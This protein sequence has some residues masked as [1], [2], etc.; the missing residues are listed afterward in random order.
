MSYPRI[1]PTDRAAPVITGFRDSNTLL[2]SLLTGLA[3]EG[4]IVDQSVGDVRTGTVYWLGDFDTGDW[5][6]WSYLQGGQHISPVGAAGQ[7]NTNTGGL[8]NT[9]LDL[10]TSPT[11]HGTGWAAKL[12]S[13]NQA[14]VQSLS[15][16][17]ATSGNFTLSWN[18]STSATIAW[19]ETTANIGTK[20]NAMASVITDGGVYVNDSTSNLGSGGSLPGKTIYI[21]FKTPG[22]HSAFTVGNNTVAGGTP[23]ITTGTTLGVPDQTFITSTTT[24]STTHTAI[25]DDTYYGFSIYV[26]SSTQGQ[27]VPEADTSNGYF[28]TINPIGEQLGGAIDTAGSDGASVTNP[29]LSVTLNVDANGNFVYFGNGGARWLDSSILAFDTWIDIVIHVK[30]QADATGIFEVWKNGTKVYSINHATA[31]VGGKTATEFDL[32]NYHAASSNTMTWYMDEMRIGDSYS[33]VAP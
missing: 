1:G 30:W 10:V 12:T 24:E 11:R 20:L 17:G 19:N 33:A 28:E 5:S 31:F 4:W 23:T 32:M 15:D 25:G 3:S 22:T 6:Q 18:G 29:K 8:G 13:M 2:A 9:T 16:T 14:W 26:P 7:D 21:I 27:F